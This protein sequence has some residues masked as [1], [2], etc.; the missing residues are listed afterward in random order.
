M[1]FQKIS[2]DSNVFLG[3]DPGC[4]LDETRLCVIEIRVLEEV[5]IKR[6]A[7]I[8]E[9]VHTVTGAIRKY[10]PENIAIE[11][12]PQSIHLAELLHKTHGEKIEGV[13]VTVS[14]G[15]QNYVLHLRPF[16]ALTLALL[17]ATKSRP[18]AGGS[19]A[20]F[21]P[22]QKNSHGMG[23]KA[24][25]TYRLDNARYGDDGVTER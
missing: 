19:Y 2:E 17:A 1:E 4:G 12:C 13:N 21:R 15:M 22:R 24:A 23:R 25:Q 5:D 10:A 7:S 20:R 11:T 14:H 9:I 3:V 18:K 16:N 6:E 8:T